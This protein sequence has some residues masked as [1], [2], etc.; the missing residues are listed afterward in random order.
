MGAWLTRLNGRSLPG[1]AAL[2][3]L[4]VCGVAVLVA[5]PAGLL[6]GW[7]GVGA[8]TAAAATCLVGALIALL[9]GEVLQAR[10]GVAA[11]VLVGMAARMGVPLVFVLIV[12]L[13]GGPLANAGFVYYL[14]IFYPVTLAVETVMSLPRSPSSGRSSNASQRVGG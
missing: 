13:H 6:G 5:L 11:G 4:F 3:T 1:R 8:S 10:H 7:P 14:L 12:H 9:L 2:L